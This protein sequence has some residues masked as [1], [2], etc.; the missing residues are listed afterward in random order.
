VNQKRETAHRLIKFFIDLD[1]IGGDTFQKLFLAVPPYKHPLRSYV[2]AVSARTRAELPG[3]PG[4]HMRA[5]NM[6]EPLAYSIAEACEAG[7]SGRTSIYNA[8][9][10][11]EL[12]AVKRGRRT[13]ILASDLRRWLE[14][15]P[16]IAPRPRDVSTPPPGPVKVSCISAETTE[17]KPS[18][19]LKRSQWRQSQRKKPSP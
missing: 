7:R 9:S 18:E 1:L 10:D 6:N 11:G 4:Q 17:P 13:L 16:A 5:I 12:R 8:I 3:C 15:L 14:G 19:S 2:A